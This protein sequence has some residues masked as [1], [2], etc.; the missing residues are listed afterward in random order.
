MELHVLSFPT[1]FTFLIFMFMVLKMRKKSKTNHSTINLPPGPWKLPIIGNMHQFLGSL[2]HRALRDLSKK[3]GPLMHLQLGEVSTIVI[4]SPEFAKEVM[5]THDIIFASRPSILATKILSYGSTNI[6]FAPYGNYWRQLRKICTLE[7]LSLKRVESYRPIREEEVSSLIKWIASKAGSPINL[8]EEVSS[9]ISGI[10]SRA[11]FG[12]KCQE[13]ETFI[14]VA[15]EA[16]EV[17][18]GF[19]IADVFP[20]FH[21]LHLIS[22][23]RTK[24]ERLHREA[25][26]IMENIINEH[27]A[28]ARTKAAEDATAE[29]L[30]D[31]LLKFQEHGDSEFSLTTDNIK[32][33]IL[34]IFSAGSETSATTLNWAMSEM[35]KHPR[36]MKAAQDEVREVFDRKWVVDE[37]AITEMK[38]LKAVVKETLRLHPPGPLLLPRECSESCVIN[39]YE[40][41]VKTK[42]LVNV[43]AIG[44]DPKYWSEPER[45]DPE[46]FLDSSIDYKGTN[47]DYLPFGAGRRIC[48]GIAFGLT[49]VELPLALFLYHFDW[50]LPNGM[51]HEDLDMT[52]FFG[53]AVRRKHDLNLIPILCRLNK[54]SQPQ[55]SN[56]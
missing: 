27:K 21:L 5:K 19:N 16:F 25:D 51:R 43:W 20:S 28:Q 29:D 34:D 3:H 6:A 45:F 18:G 42:V 31:V 2:P 39:G 36:V 44:R 56:L 49:N 13:Q 23:V 10:I 50:K 40:I 52:E 38:Y 15:K 9:T 26:R 4:S 22:G 47:W 33:V 7:L 35:I 41:P 54:L 32:A 30:V 8:T 37:T 11:A 14:S 24:L 46:R 17:G 12:K 48:P 55:S 53:V 1:L